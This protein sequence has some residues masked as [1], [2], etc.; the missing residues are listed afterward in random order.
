MSAR[1]TSALAMPYWPGSSIADRRAWLEGAAEAAGESGDEVVRT[2]VRANR[3]ELVM[4][5]GDPEGGTY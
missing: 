2:V 5:C 4:S 1:A 3:T